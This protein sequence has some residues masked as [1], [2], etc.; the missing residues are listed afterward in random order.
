MAR[1]TMLL[2]AAPRAGEHH[3]PHEEPDDERVDEA[4]TDGERIVTRQALLS[5]DQMCALTVAGVPT[6]LCAVTSLVDQASVRL[7][8]CSASGSQGTG[9]E[10]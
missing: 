3:A 7:R 5:F 8:V 9:P 6:Q 2:R 4:Q 10:L 1:E